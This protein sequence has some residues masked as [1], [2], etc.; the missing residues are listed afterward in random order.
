LYLLTQ[1]E[2]KLDQA[3][4]DDDEDDNCDVIMLLMLHCFML[5]A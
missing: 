5:V 2:D 4:D 3:R 1:D